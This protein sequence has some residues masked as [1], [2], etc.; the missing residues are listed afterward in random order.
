MELKLENINKWYPNP[1]SKKAIHAIKDFSIT[2][3]E[4]IYGLIGHN[5]AGKSTLIKILT[6]NLQP[7]TGYI[8]LE[9]K[10]ISTR[11]KNYKA[12]LGYMPQQQWLYEDMTCLQFMNYMGTLKG[13]SKKV[14]NQEVQG[15]LEQVHLWEK[16]FSKIGNLSGGMKQRLLLAQAMLNGPQIL[17]L[18][19]PTAGVDP[20]ERE[21]LK[22]II[23]QN[24]GIKIVIYCTHIMSDIDQITDKRICLKK[25]RLYE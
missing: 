4:G 16:R 20:Q 7:N 6:G 2:M 12:L 5:G 11:D 18:D 24:K 1:K 13:M 22:S 15:M 25:G 19:E 14:G 17:I 8:Y 3:T 9:G 10:R 23:Q 21:H